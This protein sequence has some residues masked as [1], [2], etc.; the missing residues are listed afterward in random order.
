MHK[1]MI[2]GR[3]GKAER[4]YLTAGWNSIVPVGMGRGWR[5][6][7][8]A[9]GLRCGYRSH[10]EVLR[11]CQGAV[12]KDDMCV[13]TQLGLWLPSSMRFVLFRPEYK[14]IVL[15]ETVFWFATL[16]LR[17]YKRGLYSE[18]MEMRGG[19]ET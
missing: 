8:A 18:T 10:W 12:V 4:T 13:G 15:F 19:A 6:K 1:C 14:L 3:S 2:Q 16:L 7:C 17:G 9:S 11:C 5:S